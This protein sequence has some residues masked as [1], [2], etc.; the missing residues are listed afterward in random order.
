MCIVTSALFWR[1]SIVREGWTCSI[2]LLGT[3]RGRMPCQP[4]WPS[5]TAT[6]GT[7]TWCWLR[8]T[9]W[10]SKLP[11]GSRRYSVAIFVCCCCS[12]LLKFVL[13]PLCDL[14]VGVGFT[15]WILV[16]FLTQ[17]PQ[18][19]NP[20]F[21]L[22]TM[23]FPCLSFQN[24]WWPCVCTVFP[25]CVCT[26]FVFALRVYT[27]RLYL[28]SSLLRCSISWRGAQLDSGGLWRECRL[29]WVCPSASKSL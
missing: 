9:L 4:T 20:D 28:V 1:S 19:H 5:S 2:S 22:H 10:K 11:W 29:R 6:M 15:G 18:A 24:V 13:L 23:A 16:E 12:H 25:L 14:C 7:R 26:D 3:R 21:G 8:G 17:H 27:L